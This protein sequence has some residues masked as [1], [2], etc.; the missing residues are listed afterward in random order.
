M[1]PRSA[2]APYSCCSLHVARTMHPGVRW[3]LVG[4]DTSS[5]VTISRA[6]SAEGRVITMIKHLLTAHPGG[7]WGYYLDEDALAYGK[8]I[9]AGISHGAASAGMYATRRPFARNVMHSS[10]PAG[11]AQASKMT[12]V[13]EWYGFVHTEDEAY[14]R[15]STCVHSESPNDG[16]GHYL[17]EPVWAHRACETWSPSLGRCSRVYGLLERRT[18]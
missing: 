2:S 16:V 13:S 9:I 15:V 11:D 12:P 6:D 17:F 7:D 1:E 5:F 18:G 14:P 10:G 8:I 4:E 3:A